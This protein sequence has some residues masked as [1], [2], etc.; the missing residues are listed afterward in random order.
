[1]LRWNDVQHRNND[2]E[3]NDN[4]RNEDQHFTVVDTDQDTDQDLDLDN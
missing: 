3:Y 4:G 2:G 1:M